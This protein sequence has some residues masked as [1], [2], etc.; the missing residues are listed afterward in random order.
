MVHS[1]TLS[2]GPTFDFSCLQR[3]TFVSEQFKQKGSTMV[4]RLT[5]LASFLM[6]V[7]LSAPVRAN[8]LFEG[9]S[10]ILSGGVHVGYA[11]S[12]YEYDPAK[13][14][15]K[16]TYFVKTGSLG[17]DV[18]ES[19]K[20]VADEKLAPISYEYTSVVGKNTKTI[21]AKFAKGKMTA[22]VTEGGKSRTVRTD[23][24]KG[25]FL[26]SFLVY[27]MLKSKTGLSTE[28]KYDYSAIAEE[29]AEIFKGEALVQAEEAHRGFKAFRILN[30]FKDVRFISFV[31]ERGEVLST[32]A[33]ANNLVTELV[34]KPSEA[35]GSFG[36]PASVLRSLFG[37]VPLGTQNVISKSLRAEALGADSPTG[38]KTGVPPGQG[39]VIK[40]EGSKDAK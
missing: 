38:K 9:Y 12:R 25:T 21:D 33:P 8:V 22:V 7:L 29:D 5:F 34:A 1:L 24:P 13:K 23:V 35:T 27:L 19:L 17:S 39:I 18:S 36:T 28:T 31:N 16:S 14:H 15:F 40:G 30:R 3:Q 2:N 10:R 4:R 20:A 6:V 26:S 37:E 32:S 11:V